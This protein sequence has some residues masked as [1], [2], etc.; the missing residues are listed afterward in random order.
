[1]SGFFGI[2]R[3]QGGPVDLEAFE[4]MKTAMQREGFDGMETHVED[5]IAMGHLM[6]KVSPESKYDKQPLKSSCGNYILVGHFRLDYR[7]EL[8]DK[9]GLTQAELEMTPDSQLAMLAYQKWKE[10]CVHHLEG[11]WAFVLYDNWENK[12]TFFR[13]HSG[14]SCLAYRKIGSII[15]F[16]SN[17]NVL[18]DSTSYIPKIDKVQLCRLLVPGLGLRK[19]HTLFLDT[20]ILSNS[21]ILSFDQNLLIQSVEY[22]PFDLEEREIHFKYEEDYI[23]ELTSIFSLAVK[24]RLV[25][26]Q[27]NALFL[28][29]GFDSTAV[30]FY[31]AKTLS[32]QNEKLLTYTSYPYYR[33]LNV[34]DQL[35]IN[36]KPIV[37]EF[38]EMT[39]SMF[40]FFVDFPQAKFKSL[41]NN[42]GQTAFRPFV[43]IND[44]WIKGIYGMSV[45]MGVKSFLNAQLGNDVISSNTNYQYLNYL[46]NYKFGLLILTLKPFFLWILNRNSSFD[47]RDSLFADLY[48]F[49]RKQFSVWKYRRLLYEFIFLKNRFISLQEWKEELK[50]TGWNPLFVN[51]IDS[52]ANRL[53]SIKSDLFSSGINWYEH[54]FSSGMIA[55][56]PT[57]DQR[58]VSYSLALPQIYFKQKM[59]SKYIYRKWMSAQLPRSIR[60]RKNRI[61]QSA[62]VGIRVMKDPEIIQHIERCL[63]NPRYKQIFDYENMKSNFDGIMSSGKTWYQKRVYSSHLLKEISIIAYLESKN[64]V[65]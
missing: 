47:F 7:D 62:D 49:T 42:G 4:Q 56:D 41:L 39:G 12:I 34:G 16:S 35:D 54:S 22:C 27:K 10:K 61:M 19:K 8:G 5:K 33:D 37:E 38:V 40:P 18:T 43:S 64:F 59:V 58:L 11:D 20:F 60:D 9:L 50:N 15:L 32:V 30:A 63:K 23:W 1:M 46:K 51:K 6:L 14:I 24:S 21:E 44:F 48:R 28:S 57:S 29:S 52:R 55:T 65:P 53:M 25:K 13:D 45:S 3:P 2:F 17:I 31:A 36:E 26:G